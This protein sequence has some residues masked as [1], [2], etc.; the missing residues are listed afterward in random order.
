MAQSHPSRRG[1]VWSGKA[2][3]GCM[4]HF[5]DLVPEKY[6]T[7]LSWAQ[8]VPLWTSANCSTMNP[9][10]PGGWVQLPCERD[11]GFQKRHFLVLPYRLGLLANRAGLS[12][13][14]LWPLLRSNIFFSRCASWSF[15][16]RPWKYC[17]SALHI[18]NRCHFLGILSKGQRPLMAFG[19]CWLVLLAQNIQTNKLCYPEKVLCSV[20]PEMLTLVHLILQKDCIEQAPQGA[21]LLTGHVIRMRLPSLAMRRFKLTSAESISTCPIKVEC[22]QFCR[23]LFA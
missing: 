18:M 8:Y 11:S 19:L 22:I 14:G 9:T 3:L 20:Y 10:L 7:I 16:R 12:P 15:S 21:W 5:L 2:K 23:P 4:L 6:Y 1:S 13:E 17:T